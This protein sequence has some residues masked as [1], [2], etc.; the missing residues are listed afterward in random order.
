MALLSDRIGRKPTLLAFAAGFVVL[1]WPGLPADRAGGF[2]PLLLVELVGVTF[3]AGYS[4]NCAVVM[5]EQFPAEV[6]GHRHRAA[7]RAGRRPLR[8]HRPVHHHLDEHERVRRLLWLYVAAA[9]L[10]GVVVYLTM[11]ETQGKELR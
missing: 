6:R 8:W 1:A 3:L 9:A 10:V 7:V 5:A 11:P 4:A 2:W